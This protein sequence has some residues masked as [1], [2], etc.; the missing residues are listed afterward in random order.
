MT[1]YVSL[2]QRALD[3][4]E[5]V[6][7]TPFFAFIAALTAS[8]VFTTTGVIDASIWSKIGLAAIVLVLTVFTSFLKAWVWPALP[9]GVDYVLRVVLTFVQVFAGYLLANV[10]DLDGFAHSSSYSAAAVAGLGAAL[11]FAKGGLLLLFSANKTASL[12]PAEDDPTVPREY[13]PKHDAPEV[14]KAD[15]V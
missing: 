13:D 9:A 1:T 14:D 11:S 6:G 2:R 10:L 7:V 3:V 12:L 8:G 4:L 15:E 5:R